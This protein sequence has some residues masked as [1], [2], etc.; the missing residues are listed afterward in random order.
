ML[1]SWGLVVYDHNSISFRSKTQ[2]NSQSGFLGWR[3]PVV[4]LLRL[5]AGLNIDRFTGSLL[6]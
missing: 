3:V 4:F 6:R 2:T 1:F 5:Q